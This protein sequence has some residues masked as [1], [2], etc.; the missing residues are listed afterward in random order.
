MGSVVSCLEEGEEGNG[1]NVKDIKVRQELVQEVERKRERE[2][3]MCNCEERKG[4]EKRMKGREGEVRK[5]QGE[6]GVSAKGD[7]CI[8]GPKGK[9]KGR[10]RSV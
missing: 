2:R 8:K 7:E 1:K 4:R 3:E 9:K 5:R 6:G 10:R